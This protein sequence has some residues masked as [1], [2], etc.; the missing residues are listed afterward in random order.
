MSSGEEEE[1]MCMLIPN[2]NFP[3]K[4]S[5]P[6]LHEFKPDEIFVVNGNQPMNQIVSL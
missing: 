4:I 5:R 6:I 3:I 1:I 2:G